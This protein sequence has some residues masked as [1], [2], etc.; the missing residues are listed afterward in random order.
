MNMSIPK[1]TEL[2]IPPGPKASP[3]K[4]IYVPPRLTCYGDV[5]TITLGG[6]AGEGDSGSQFT[7]KPPS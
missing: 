2:D 4:R 3:V 5:R 6:S 7:Q 1:K